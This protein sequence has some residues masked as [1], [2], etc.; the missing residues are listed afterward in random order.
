MSNEDDRHSL[1]LRIAFP[2]LKIVAWSLFAFFAAPIRVKGAKNVPRTGPLLVFSNHVSNSDPVL[3][4]YAS[5][6][7]LHFMARRELF[8][9][10]LMGRFIRW[11]KAFP[12]TQSSADKG[13]IRRALDLVGSGHAVGVFPEGQLS[14]DGRLI[15]L[16]PGAA[17]LV[18]KTGAPCVCVGIRGVEKMM[19]YPT[20]T[21]RWA[22]TTVTAHW[23]EPR[24]FGPDAKAEDILDW[25]GSE[26][27]RLSGQ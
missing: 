8:T 14:P 3:V 1:G 9:M 2:F 6:R 15:E 11:F 26:L 21:P 5:P 20:A 4:Q 22:F 19:P 27:R 10:G 18:R 16:L 24:S 12:V 23:G 25:I 17:L 13:A 7:L